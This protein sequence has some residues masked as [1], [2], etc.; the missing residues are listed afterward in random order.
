MGHSEVVRVMLLRGAERD[1]ARDV[2]L[3]DSCAGQARE[4]HLLWAQRSAHTVGTR[5]NAGTMGPGGGEGVVMHACR[6]E[7]GSRG[8]ARTKAQNHG[9]LDRRPHGCVWSYPAGFSPHLH[10]LLLG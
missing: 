6:G 3:S 4:V 5:G 8:N 10:L 2:S 1:A 7:G 9:S